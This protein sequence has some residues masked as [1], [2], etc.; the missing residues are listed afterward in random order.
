MPG[1][2]IQRSLRDAER[3]RGRLGRPTRRRERDPVFT[4]RFGATDTE[5]LFDRICRENGID[6]EAPI[7]AFYAYRRP[8]P[9]RPLPGRRTEGLLRGGGGLVR[10]NRPGRSATTAR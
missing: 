2:R 6:R 1:W 8:D 3:E 4:G 7:Q 9:Q 5:V 10:L